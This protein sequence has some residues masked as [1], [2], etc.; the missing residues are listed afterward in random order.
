MEQTLENRII[1]IDT[2]RHDD[3]YYVGYKMLTKCLETDIFYDGMSEALKIAQDYM[4]SDSIVLLKKGED[5]E[6][7]VFDKAKG[8]GRLRG[9]ILERTINRKKEYFGESQYVD[10]TLDE[11]IVKRLTTLQIVPGEDEYILAIMNNQLKCFA[12]NMEFM[13]IMKNTINNLLKKYKRMEEIKKISEIDSL[14]SLYNRMAYRRRE[15][16]LDQD[17]EIPVT[18]ALID[19]FRLKYTNDNINHAAGDKYISMTAILL[20]KA[21]R[22]KEE[23]IPH[24]DVVYRV[25]GDEFI[26]ISE[27]KTKE[28]VEEILRKV[29]AQVELFEFSNTSETPTGINYG[30]IERTNGE[31]I[32]R[33]YVMADQILTADKNK[34]YKKLGIDRRK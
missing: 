22:R 30:V 34:T 16:E 5:G 12:D 29:G 3:P 17:K 14:T 10:T 11:G 4:R 23:P 7:T 9:K 8:Q 6:Y 25:G 31:P 28:E 21:F 24:D 26:L 18:L 33:L 32:E 2:H 1:D 15:A 13:G 20:K 19:L 27:T